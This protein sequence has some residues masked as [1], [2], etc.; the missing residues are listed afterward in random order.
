[1]L[2]L[3]A[4]GMLLLASSGCAVPIAGKSG[5]VHYLI[6]G[7][8]VVNVPA[9][10]QDTSSSAVTYDV[11]GLLVS[12]QPGVRVAAGYASGSTVQVPVT[13]DVLISAERSPMG[14]VTVEQTSYAKSNRTDV[15]GCR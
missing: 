13:A 14:V 6:V 4:A 3:I 12:N 1:M 7:I 5:T 9:P 15:G 8:G 10:D 11:V 2:R